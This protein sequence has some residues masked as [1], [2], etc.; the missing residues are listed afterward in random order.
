MD[1]L[2]SVSPTPAQTHVCAFKACRLQS[3]EDSSSQLW[4][5]LQHT[6]RQQNSWS[7]SALCSDTQRLLQGVWVSMCAPVI[8]NKGKSFLDCCRRNKSRIAQSTH[9]SACPFPG[10]PVKGGSVWQMGMLNRLRKR[11]LKDYYGIHRPRS[12][13]RRTA[14][15]SSGWATLGLQPKNQMFEF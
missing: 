2:G 13:Y 10:Q 14:S 6:Q 9:V 1:I 7:Q 8:P 15:I 3:W 12:L 11:R 4:Q 5:L